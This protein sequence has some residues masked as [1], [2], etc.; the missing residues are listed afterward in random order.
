M[1]ET[2]RDIT[3]LTSISVS[4]VKDPHV[5]TNLTDPDTSTFWQSDGSLPHFIN[6]CLPRRFFVSSISI[7]LSPETDASYSPT[8]I[9][10]RAGEHPAEL[11]QIMIV[12]DLDLHTGWFTIS[13]LEASAGAGIDGSIF[14]L[15]LLT[16]LQGGRDSTLRQIRIS[17]VVSKQSQF[18]SH[19]FTKY[20]ARFSIK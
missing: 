19:H 10:V 3:H 16:N 11:R 15:V 1:F 13:L 7:Y 8:K 14:Q 20:C 17:S 6:L 18:S 4:S 5:H 2:E 9:A 12:D